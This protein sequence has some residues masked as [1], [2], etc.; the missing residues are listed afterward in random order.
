MASNDAQKL[1]GGDRKDILSNRSTAY[2]DY[3]AVSEMD[4]QRDPD[5]GLCTCWDV[6]TEG[7][8]ETP[9]KLSRTVH[10]PC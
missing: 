6:D 10:S 1:G 3:T 5:N 9:E 8:I 7:A 4:V 2:S